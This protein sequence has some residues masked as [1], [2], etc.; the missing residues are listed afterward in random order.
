MRRSTYE[1]FNKIGFSFLYFF[2]DL[3]C[4]FKD[5]V[6]IKKKRKREKPLPRH[7]QTAQGDYVNGFVSQRRLDGRFCCLGRCRCPDLEV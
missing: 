7:P 3:L 4:F 1:E 5:L 6:K 2:C